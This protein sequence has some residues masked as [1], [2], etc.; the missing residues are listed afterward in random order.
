M[1]EECYG[2][3]IQIGF[4]RT[5]IATAIKALDPLS[6]EIAKNEYLNLLS[7]EEVLEVSGKYYNI[8]SIISIINLDQY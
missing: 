2:E 4:I 7:Q 3:E 8:S 5:D 1:I 6:W